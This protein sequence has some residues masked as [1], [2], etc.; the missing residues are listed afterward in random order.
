MM[1]RPTVL[2]AGFP[3]RMSMMRSVVTW[4]VQPT[5]RV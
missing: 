3:R 2:L 5:D 1:I 4:M